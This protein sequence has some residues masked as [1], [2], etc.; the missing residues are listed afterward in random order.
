[1]SIQGPT[2]SQLEDAQRIAIAQSRFTAEHNAPCLQLISQFRLGSG[3]KSLTVPKV[4]QMTALDL[5]DGVDLVGS[6]DI[7]MT[8]TSLT[9]AD[10]GL[11]VILTDA[12]VTQE[13]EDVF[14]IVG[15]QMGDAVARKKD[16]DVISLFTGFSATQLGGTG[17]GFELGNVLDYIA[18]AK[19][20]K[21]PAPV[22]IVTNPIVT[23]QLGA[24]L[25]GYTQ[26]AGGTGATAIPKGLNAD[27]LQDYFE[28]KIG[29]VAIFQ[30]GNVGADS[31]GDV[32]G[33]IFSREAMAHLE[34]VALNT[35]RQRD[36]SLRATE[37]I[38]TSRFGVF[39]LDD[40]YGNSI[41]N[42]GA[43]AGSN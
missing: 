38:T 21:F 13:V 24:S 7:N 42:D 17:V 9:A 20:S 36:A 40:N 16:N 2:S 29:Q 5:V 26:A 33:C 32:V 18:T 37:L 19:N 22:F 14:K 23:M 12:L 28:F 31:S 4:G 8:S 25:W 6:E 39:E 30:D 1:M 27:L 41:K 10:I 35:E 15:K 3:E 11:K 34:S 43:S